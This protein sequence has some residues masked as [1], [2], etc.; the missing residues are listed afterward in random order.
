[1]EV[2]CIFS[3]KELN[4]T[5]NKIYKVLNKRYIDDEEGRM[6]QSE[7][8]IENDNGN[9]EWYYFQW[10]CRVNKDEPCNS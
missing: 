8:F 2:K 9:K 5:E 1:M 4:I 7:Y 10:F 6:F 3:C